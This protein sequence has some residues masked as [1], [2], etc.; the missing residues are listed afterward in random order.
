M[1]LGEKVIIVTGASRGLGLSIVQQLVELGYSVIGCSRSKT[2][3]METLEA[4]GSFQPENG[5]GWPQKNAKSAKKG[6]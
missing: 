4:G 3:E 1:S 2:K 6:F 5:D